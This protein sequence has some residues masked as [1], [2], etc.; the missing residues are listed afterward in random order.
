MSA[1]AHRPAL[2]LWLNAALRPYCKVPLVEKIDTFELLRLG[3]YI[4]KLTRIIPLD[5][6]THVRWKDVRSALVVAKGNLES[7]LK[8]NVLDLETA[9]DAGNELLA[10]VSKGVEGAS[11][12]NRKDTL[13]P[14]LVT[15]LQVA[16]EA[17]M[18]T[19]RRELPRRPTYVV[20]KKGG[21]REDALIDNGEVL[22]PQE[23]ATK[24]PDAVPD[25]KQG[26]R[27]I[28]FEL[29]TAAGYHLHR[30]NEAVLRVYYDV[31][32]GG[33]PRPRNRSMGNYLGEMDKLGV[34]DPKIKSSLQDLVKHHRNPLIHPEHSLANVNEAIALLNGVHTAIVAMLPAIP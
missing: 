26:A 10:I 11:D 23:L 4:E 14:I 33:A 7:F 17:F 34:G 31:V 6:I 15:E 30:A 21:F 24:V 25:I 3:M 5:P 27:C 13:P 1:L 32:T 29:P 12:P 2:F 20:Q 8:D 28:A 19:L 18:A 16:V 9:L 22:F